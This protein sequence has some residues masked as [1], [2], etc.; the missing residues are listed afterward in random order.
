M[1]T[2]TTT[3]KAIDL[4]IGQ[5]A[6][7]AGRLIHQQDGR[8]EFSQFAYDERWLT[9][10][11]GFDISPD[12]SRRPGY[13]LRKKNSAG[14]SCFF[15]ALADTAPDAWGRRVIARA[16]AKSRARDRS[17][18]S[19][20]ELDYLMAVDDHSRVGAI[21]LVDPNGE[22]AGT[23]RHGDRRTPPLLE[24]GQIL[25]ASRAVELSQ[26]TAEDLAYLQ[27]RGTSLGGMRPKCT[28][29]D[30]DGSLAIGKFPS[31]GDQR[32]VT[33]G[34]VLALR[35]AQ[36]AGL[37]AA[38]ARIILVD[39]APIAI[40][41][42]FDRSP[43]QHR[44]P[45]LSAASLIEA[46]RDD[47]RAYTELLDRM[48]IHCRDFAQDARELWRRLV[49]NHMITNVDDHL[50]NTGFLY[51]GANL[52]RLAPAFDLNPFP[53]KRPESKTWL[54][55]ETGPVTSIQQLLV[56]APRFELDKHEALRILAEVRD[57]IANWR[58]VAS[59]PDIGMSSGEASEFEAAMEGDAAKEA[60]EVLGR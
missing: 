44:I 55:E 42:R 51:S 54:S 4:R 38:E 11:D 26:E 34:E 41:R 43:S 46:D 60:R 57:S 31:V 28:L 3:R 45:Y 20:T 15:H 5:G 33:Q 36:Q 10:P 21:R 8:R 27:G 58:G 19:L 1:H 16:H 29:I 2:R 17:I 48:R 7:L 52:W 23:T 35:L 32:C 47:E 12:L 37:E 49:F 25:K 50:Q 24:V 40:I 6:R 39:G 22:T 13:Q 18:G 9:D 14:G 56:E 59:H 30:T 53:D